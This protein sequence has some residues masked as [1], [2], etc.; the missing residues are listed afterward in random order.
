MPFWSARN[1]SIR[2][3]EVLFFYPS[4][5]TPAAAAGHWRLL[6]HGC[7]YPTRIT[8]FRRQPIVALVRSV[9]GVDPSA[10]E[11]FRKRIRQFLVAGRVGRPVRVQLSGDTHDV[12][13]SGVAGLF[14]R[15]VEIPESR[16]ESFERPGSPTRWIRYRALLAGG[17]SR[18]FQGEV[19]LLSQ[20]GVSVISDIDDTLKHSNVPDRRDLFHN[21]FVREFRPIPGMP[22]LYR[23]AALEGVAFHYVSGSPWQLYEP[24]RDFWERQHLPLGSFHLKPFR[25]RDT[26][27]KLQLAQQAPHKSAVIEPLLAAFPQRKFLLFG[28]SGEQD[29]EIYGRFLRDR[30]QQIVGVFIRNVRPEQTREHSRFQQAFAGTDPARWTLY[31][32]VGEVSDRAIALC[33]GEA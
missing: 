8:W 10:D 14:A 22:E 6:V 32:D 30:P 17:D 26:A 11:A 24:L 4:Y 9:M 13:P 16:M 29:P 7:V 19:Q 12:G 27:R 1:L 15:H 28:D 25:L 20:S 33:R 21:T 3:D 18:E 31:R 2:R 23:Q 5:G